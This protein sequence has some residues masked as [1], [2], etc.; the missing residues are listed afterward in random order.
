VLENG[1][2]TLTL[3]GAADAVGVTHATLQHHFG[4]REQL[5]E[6][7]IEHLLK[8]SFAPGEDDPVGATVAE[9]EVRLRA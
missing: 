4:G 5:L 9:V 3:P 1:V 6:E 7:I 8:R 2:A